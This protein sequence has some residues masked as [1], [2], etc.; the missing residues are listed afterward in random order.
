MCMMNA[1]DGHGR[2]AKMARP[3]SAVSPVSAG[4]ERRRGEIK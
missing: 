3:T 1:T 4:D 2:A